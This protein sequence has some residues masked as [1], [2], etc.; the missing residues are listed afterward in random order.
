MK[1]WVCHQTPLFFVKS[2][3]HSTEKD[4]VCFTFREMSW[5][6]L[7]CKG[8]NVCSL[9]ISQVGKKDQ[10]SL[11]ILDNLSKALQKWNRRPFATKWH[12]IYFSEAT[13]TVGGKAHKTFTVGDAWDAWEE[14]L[15]RKS[16]T[17]WQGQLLIFANVMLAAL[18]LLHNGFYRYSA[19]IFYRKNYLLFYENSR[20]GKMLIKQQFSALLLQFQSWLSNYP[21]LSRESQMLSYRKLLKQ[22]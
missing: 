15:P 18:L 22:F 21:A 3:A 12:L 13:T 11:N 16:K 5:C 6:I 1:W 10:N 19:I 20:C 4:C 17:G 14:K 8:R 7:S 2:G 9:Y